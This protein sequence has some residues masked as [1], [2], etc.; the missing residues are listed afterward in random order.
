ME[1]ILNPKPK[2]QTRVIYPVILAVPDEQ[3]KLA[4]REKVAFLSRHARG[5]LEISAQKSGVELTHLIKGENG[6]PLPFDGNYWSLTHKT[7]YVGGVIASTKIGMDLEKI[8]PCSAALFRKTAQDSEWC[9]SNADPTRLFFRYWTSKESVIKASGAGIRD[10]SK[11]RIVKIID[12][13][14][15]IINYRDQE[16][17]IEHHD[18]DGH[19]VSVVKNNFNVKWTILPAS[20][21]YN[22][23]KHVG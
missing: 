13:N 7:G 19:I 6:E 3:Q 2:L 20:L 18:F 22:A 12:H 14:R 9:L 5:A 1:T 17:I 23:E 16:W 21:N 4:G 15:L 8:R 10:L 11:C